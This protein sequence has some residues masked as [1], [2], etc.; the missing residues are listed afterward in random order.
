MAKNWA[1]A[2]GINQYNPNNFAPLNY[3]KRDAELM[4]DFFH[5][6]GFDEV[7]FFTDDSPPQELANGAKIPT[8]PSCGNL[9]SFLHDRFEQPFLNA[10]DNCWFFFAGH[11]LQ[12]GNHDYLMP[13]D[14]HP[15]NANIAIPVSYVRDRLSRCGADN[16]IL[17]LDAC[18]SEG[19]RDAGRIGNEAHQ[20]VITISACSPTERSWEI[21]ALEQGVFT[22]A[23]LEALQIG[24]DRNCATVERLSQYLRFRIPDL[25]RQYSKTP[26]QTPRISTDPTEKLHFILLPQYATL[27][28]VALLKTDAY[29]LAFVDKNPHLAQQLC[30]RAIA[31]SMGR[32]MELLKLYTQIQRLLDESLPLV[33]P[34]VLESG[35]SGREEAIAQ[36]PLAE[37]DE[38]DSLWEATEKQSAFD[39]LL[40]ALERQIAEGNLTHSSGEEGEGRSF[41]VELGN[42]VSLEMVAIPGG[43][44]WMGSADDEGGDDDHPRHQVTVAPFWIGKFTVTQ[45]QYEAVIG[46]NPSRFKGANRPVEKV[47]W[48]DAVEFCQKLSAKANRQFRLPSEAEWEYA[49]RAGT[50]TPFYFGDT[51]STDQANYDGNRIYGS[52]KKGEYREKTTNVG[53]FLSNAFGL[54]D[55]H[56]NVWEWCLDHYHDSYQGAPTNGSA[57]IDQDPKDAAEKLIRG[58]SWYSVPRTCCSTCRSVC[59]DDDD[60][61]HG[62]SDRIGFRVV[63]NA[64]K[65]LA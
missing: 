25:C 50:T 35:R 53:S 63:C 34:P 18:R 9:L 48:N 7:C 13:I 17:M 28:D 26:S 40:E 46:G 21:E 1:I 47:S 2:I 32:D 43:T 64:P 30:I 41:V 65:T 10:G 52:G 45:A 4:R 61:P 11:G 38:I 3:A 54:Y 56:G 12:H 14:A 27:A 23:L 29:R 39:P 49:C 16:V 57:W 24:G 58:G 5:R 15:R 6:A 59:R 44:F 33:I 19:S 20:G 31:A 60:F 36:N 37:E 8:Y 42:G 62:T 55:M 22:Y 51:I